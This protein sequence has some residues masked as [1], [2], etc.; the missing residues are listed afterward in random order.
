MAVVV[1]ADDD[2]KIRSMLG[3]IIEKLGHTVFTAADAAEVM[4]LL[5]HDPQLLVLDIDMPGETGVELVM[6]LRHHPQL[7]QLPV[8]FVTAFPER[9]RPLQL[10]GL[11]AVKVISKPF[12]LPEIQTT[13]RDM[14]GAV[15]QAT[16]K[17]QTG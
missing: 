4:A 16:W 2:A 8:I 17:P 10:T 9:S 11:G 5:R 13:V 1:V 7:A 12:H 15:G 3:S 14:L 6:K